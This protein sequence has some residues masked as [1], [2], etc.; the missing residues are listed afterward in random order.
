[1]IEAHIKIDDELAAKG[2]K[3]ALRFKAVRDISYYYAA[4]LMLVWIVIMIVN[5]LM[6]APELSKVHL[7]ALALVW[8]GAS[9]H[10]YL[11]W[12]KKIAE[13]RGWSFDAR[14]DARGVTTDTD[15]EQH[16]DWDYYKG[17][18]EFDDYLEIE[19]GDGG[20]SFLPKRPELFEVIEYTK[21]KIPRRGD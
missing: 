19:M 15:R 6:N 9:V 17:Y 20:F 5:G 12:S 2:Y 18:R 8:I 14:L 21:E 13:T 1:M 11:D 7:L 16:H 4:R 10:G 3:K